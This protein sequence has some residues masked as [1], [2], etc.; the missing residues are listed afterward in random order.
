M[1][2]TNKYVRPSSLKNV[3]ICSDFE[4]DQ[5]QELHPVT[6]AGT[7][8]HKAMELGDTADLLEE[9]IWLYDKA[10]ESQDELIADYFDKP[11]GDIYKELIFK[12]EAGNYLG[13]T[14]LLLID[15]N[16]NGLEIDYKFGF[17]KVDHP[18]DNTQFQRY[19]V[20]TFD[21]FPEL[22]KL[23]VAVIGPRFGTAYWDYTRK[24]LADLRTR[25][26]MIQERAG[27]GFRNA[28]ATCQY[29][30]H[31]GTCEEVHKKFA[32]ANH[33]G[34]LIP[35]VN[36]NMDLT[37]PA[38]VK[39]ALEV[40]PLFEKFYKDWSKTINTTALEMLDQGIEIEGFEEKTRKGRTQVTDIENVDME[41]GKLGVTSEKYKACVTLS[42]TDLIKEVRAIAPKGKKGDYEANF[43]ERIAPYT[44]VGESTK[45]VGRVR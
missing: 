18:K 5:T 17:N 21:R 22:K 27:K 19:V 40:K 10:T 45:Y 38:D 2:T 4:Q 12:D 32:S 14:D 35:A 26:R 20:L 31:I 23:R 28:S 39:K 6:E 29:C 13:T 30:K 25:E 41:A 11:A 44:E 33:W 43:R 9:E 3:E 7:R 42:L 16:G 34:E 15:E 37:N 8:L 1:K 24:D 36:P